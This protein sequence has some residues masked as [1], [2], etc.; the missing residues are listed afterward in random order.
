[1]PGVTGLG[2]TGALTTATQNPGRV[3]QLAKGRE[4]RPQ[5]RKTRRT[6]VRARK[7]RTGKGQKGRREEGE[8]GRRAKGAGPSHDGAGLT[9]RLTGLTGLT[10]GRAWLGNYINGGRR[11]GEERVG[12]GVLL[13]RTARHALTALVVE[14]EL[15]TRVG[16][17]LY[18][19]RY[20]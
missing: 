10:T 16:S 13:P 3:E 5:K 2:I 20:C 19:C 18:F 17:G 7:G 4:S 14:A 8:E 9:D 12:R 6:G 1:M 15:D 11:S